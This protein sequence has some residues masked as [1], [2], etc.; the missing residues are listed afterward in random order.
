[1]AVYRFLQDHSIGGLYYS[2]GTTASTQDVGGTL[3]TS[4]VPTPNCDP[5]DAPAVAAFYAAGPLRPVLFQPG[6]SFQTPPPKTF[7][8]ATAVPGSGF[9]SYQL[10]G[11]GALLSPIFA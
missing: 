5:L 3:P 7:W 10:T 8:I 9:T 1:M 11:L 2:V 6:R 4:F